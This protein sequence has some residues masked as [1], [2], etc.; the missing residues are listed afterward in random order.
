MKPHDVWSLCRLLLLTTASCGLLPVANAGPALVPD[1]GIVVDV[2]PADKMPGRGAD[3]PQADM[4]ARADGFKRITHISHPVMTVFPAPSGEKP[5][6]AMIVCPGGA[7]TYVVHDKEGTEIAAWLNAR[8]ITAIVLSYRVPQNRD[9]ALQDLQRA[10]SMARARSADWNIDPRQLGVIGFSAGGHLCARTAGAAGERTY[11]P[12]D[13]S[14]TQSCRPDFSV[15]V[16]PAFLERKGAVPPE[17][18]PKPGTPPTLI[19]HTEDDAKFV[20][21]SRLYAA[22]LAAERIPHE[23]LVY[24]TGGH[25]YG[26]RSTGDAR[27]WPDA[28]LAWLRQNKFL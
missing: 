13:E 11:A 3:E 19:L 8:G 10:L 7:Y 1:R 25:G 18:L 24:P 15:L 12:V 26:L 6:P 2:W 9:G 4:P 22:A 5:A 21:G 28:C 23:L 20:P 27:L 14:D 17:L 16:Y